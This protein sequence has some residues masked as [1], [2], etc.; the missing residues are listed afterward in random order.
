[1]SNLKVSLPLVDGS[2]HDF[3][4]EG[5]SCKK[6]IH[7]LYTDDF[8]APPVCMDIQIRTPSGKTVKVVIPYDVNGKASVFI[9]NSEV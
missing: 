9:D 8:A 6:I 4:Y 3:L 1:M 2:L 7:N 5:D